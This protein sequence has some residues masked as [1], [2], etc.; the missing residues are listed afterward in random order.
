MKAVEK[1]GPYIVVA[2]LSLTSNNGYSIIRKCEIKYGESIGER[3][4]EEKYLEK[5]LGQDIK[6]KFGLE[7]YQIGVEHDDKKVPL[8]NKP[9]YACCQS[10]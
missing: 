8:P 9:I 10:I 5:E 6:S 1:L 3:A 2:L 7:C 4:L